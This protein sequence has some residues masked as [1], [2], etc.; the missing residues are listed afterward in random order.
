MQKFAQR[1]TKEKAVDCER[2]WIDFNQLDVIE[3]DNK[4]ILGS[5]GF[6]SVKLVRDRRSQKLYALKEVQ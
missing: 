1:V 6:A 5:G 2:V 4:K 3:K